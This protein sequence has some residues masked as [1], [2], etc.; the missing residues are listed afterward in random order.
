MQSLRPH[1]TD[2][3]SLQVLGVFK[4][5]GRALTPS[6]SSS[7]SPPTSTSDAGSDSSSQDNYTRP[8]LSYSARLRQGVIY[9]LEVILFLLLATFPIFLSYHTGC[10]SSMS[11]TFHVCCLGFW[12]VCA[13]PWVRHR[14]QQEMPNRLEYKHNEL[15]N[16]LAPSSPFAYPATYLIL[17]TYILPAAFVSFMLGYA[18]H[19]GWVPVY[20]PW[21]GR[22]N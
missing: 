7:P 11:S 5:P 17:S 16:R 20:D 6:A 19:T 22:R 2:L 9:L 13:H 4:L 8:T 18:G 21:M 10:R 3:H 15:P 14:V 12:I 1:Q